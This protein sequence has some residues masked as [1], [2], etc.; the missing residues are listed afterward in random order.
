MNNQTW[1]DIEELSNILGILRET[2][3]RNCI[4]NKYVSKSVKSGKSKNY[5]ILVSSLPQ[6]YQD[7]YYSQSNSNNN[8]LNLEIYTNAPEWARKQANKYMNLFE[9]TAGM[10]FKQIKEFINEWNLKYPEKKSSYSSFRLAKRKYDK[11][12]ISGLISKNGQRK[13]ISKVNDDYFQYFKSFF[14]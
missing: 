2:L 1:I 4:S 11:E 10:N 12:G 9:L 14:Y 13:G 5:K 3:R 8:D 6:N 7:K